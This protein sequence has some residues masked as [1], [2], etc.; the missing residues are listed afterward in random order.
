MLHDKHYDEG[1]R[2]TDTTYKASPIQLELL[3][4]A[5]KWERW[6]TVTMNKDVATSLNSRVDERLR[7]KSHGGGVCQLSPETRERRKR[8][9]GTIVSNSVLRCL[10]HQESYT[11]TVPRTSVGLRT[12]LSRLEYKHCLSHSSESGHARVHRRRT[13]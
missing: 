12:L 6:R 8:T 3:I 4:G 13:E 11:E 7:T 2:E 5:K 9:Q 10:P 1:R